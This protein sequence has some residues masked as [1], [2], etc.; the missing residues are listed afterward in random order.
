VPTDYLWQRSPFQLSGGGSGRVENAGID[1]ILPYWMARYYG[2]LGADTVRVVSA[3]SGASALAPGAIAS[4][5]GEN[6]AGSLE[7]SRTQPPPQSLGGVSVAVKDSAGVSRLA[8]V[9][10]VSASQINFVMPADMTPGTASVTIQ[11]SGSLPIV[12]SA[13]V[14][15]VAPTLFTADASGKG[16]AA[17][18]AIEIVAGRQV[19]LP[20]FLCSGSTCSPVPIQL[21]VDTPIYLSL[22]GTGIRNRSS[23]GDV[24]CTIGGIAVPVLDAGAQPEFA[25]L[26]QVN[27]ALTLSLRSIGET[28]VIV[29]VDGQPSNSVRINVQ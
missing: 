24:S 26:D 13:E 18:T 1:Y 19:P 12:T 17:A 28:D 22:Y 10:F 11:N 25:G 9:Y 15:T 14:H 2:V 16:V 7:R 6:L 8:G 29:T 23:L 21:G 27:V 3:A 20:V 4:V 5:F